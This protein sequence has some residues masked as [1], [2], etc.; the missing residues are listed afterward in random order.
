MVSKIYLLPS[1]HHAKPILDEIFSQDRVLLNRKSLK[2]AGF[3]AT[4]PRK[5]TRLIIAR[6]DKLTGYI[7]KLYLDNQRYYKE[8]PEHKH[9]IQR[10]KGANL[11][12]GEIEKKGWNHL[13]KV[14]KKWIYALPS[15]PKAPEEFIA[16]NFILIEED[17]DLLSNKEN[18]KRW[19][20]SQVS[21]EVLSAL[22]HLVNTLGLHDCLKPDNVPFSKDS[23]VAFID[24]QFY[25]DSVEMKQFGRFLSKKNKK[26]WDM[27]K[28]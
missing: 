7:F 5:F 23:R 4:K 20:S 6:H 17:M 2:K 22:F 3:E 15:H 16:K 19:K 13:F 8:T 10:I 27:I 18:K 26:F 9:W 11:I 1:D 12:R 28:H 25:G 21:E 14:P 24:T